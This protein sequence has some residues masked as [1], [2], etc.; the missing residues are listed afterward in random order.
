MIKKI[1]KIGNSKGIILDQTLL[2][3]LDIQDETE[4]EV[5]IKDNGL[6]IQK[7]S[8]SQA[9]KKVSKKHQASLDKLGE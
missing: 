6:L 7:M 3:L 5:Q 8:V 4:V 9:Y 2:K 1:Q